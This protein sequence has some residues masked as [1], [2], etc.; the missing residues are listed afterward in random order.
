MTTIQIDE[1]LHKRIKEL[2]KEKKFEIPT[3]VKGVVDL[4]VYR[5]LEENIIERWDLLKIMSRQNWQ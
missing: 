1:E 3:T 2:I 5:V 4:I